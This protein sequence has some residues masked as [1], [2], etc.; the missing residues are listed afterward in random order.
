MFITAKC[1][2][3]HHRQER[4]EIS[5]V[6]YK[7]SKICYLV[8]ILVSQEKQHDTGLLY[9]V[10]VYNPKCWQLE[11]RLM[12]HK[13]DSLNFTFGVWTVLMLPN[14]CYDSVY[15]VTL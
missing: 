5:R 4:I 3:S 14:V 9:L 7:C 11:G 12:L 10:T 8:K 6:I 13:S 15:F 2:S 1:Y